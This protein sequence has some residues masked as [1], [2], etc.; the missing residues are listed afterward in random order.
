M[1][2]SFSTSLITVTLEFKLKLSPMALTST[3][4]VPPS[5]PS[6]LYEFVISVALYSC[7]PPETV[8]KYLVIPLTLVHVNLPSTILMPVG[9]A[10]L[11]ALTSSVASEFIYS[12]LSPLAITVM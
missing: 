11:Y 2:E 1:L 9:D 5:I 7:S 10:N 6:N 8:I 4:Y 3:L 12:L